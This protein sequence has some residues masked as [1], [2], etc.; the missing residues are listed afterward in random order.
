[1]PLAGLR[2]AGRRRALPRRFGR[3]LLAGAALYAIARG[4]EGALRPLPA[5]LNVRGEPR[6][7]DEVTFLYD[8]TG[9][10][11]PGRRVFESVP[12]IEP[13]ALAAPAGRL[14]VGWDRAVDQHIFDAVFALI[15][16][17]NR[18]IVADLFL[19]NRMQGASPERTRPLAEQLT[20][21]LVAKRRSR[22][23]VDIVLITDP[24]NTVYGSVSSPDLD[25]LRAAGVTVIV[26]DLTRLP[27]SNPLWSG[28]WRAFLQPFGRRG[29]G[30]L[31]NPFSPSGPT[32]TA[33]AWLEMLN[34][35]AN[36]RKVVAADTPHGPAAIVTSANPHDGSSAHGN[37]ALRVRGPVV[38][39]IVAS[40][41]AVA[42]MSGA[43][44]PATD[45][46]EAAG[47]SAATGVRDDATV[48]LVTEAAIREAV[49]EALDGTR[50]AD[51][52]DVAMFYLADRRVIA[53][54]TSATGRGA[55]VRVLLDPNKDAFGRTKNGVPNRPVAAE[56]RRT[57]GIEVRWCDTHGEQCHAKM[58]LV[59]PSSGR[60]TLILGSAN[61]TRRNIA[62]L[63]LE[64]DLVVRVRP[65]APAI[66][67]AA[68]YF[69]RAWSNDPERVYSADYDA[70]ADDGWPKRWLYRFM[71]ASGVSTF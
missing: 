45:W 66:S 53:A 58:V 36:H 52:V 3:W 29:R 54:L 32:V 49:L 16:G 69:E 41:R 59:R 67:D 25:A 12:G 40:E 7:V 34:F 23:D 68:A 47:P 33:R 21:R 13:P 61:L 60:A 50:S 31:P 65:D 27:D 22:P 4:A 18:G 19:F 43:T 35:K 1:M 9:I 70:Y 2:P 37:V 57:P 8:A 5:G 28:P 6:P 11:E 30:W 39:D 10:G 24:I 64:T 56:L 38:A 26:T 51:R 63:N 46:A 62:G 71:E 42:A 55:T 20:E 44:M 15:D 48:G 14:P 17:A